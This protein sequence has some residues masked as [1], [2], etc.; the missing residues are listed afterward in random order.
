[1]NKYIFYSSGGLKF[2]FLRKRSVSIANILLGEILGYALNNKQIYA[3]DIDFYNISGKLDIVNLVQ[4]LQEYK[5]F[6]R[7]IKDCSGV[8]HNGC[9][10]KKVKRIK[11]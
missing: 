6:I 3:L 2:F 11:K 10:R 5:I 7:N 1:M 8:A 4:G 9:F